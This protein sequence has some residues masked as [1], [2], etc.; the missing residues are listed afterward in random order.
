MIL[1]D[2]GTFFSL[3]YV[4]FFFFTF[5]VIFWFGSRFR[6]ARYNN[7]GGFAE[8]RSLVFAPP[9]AAKFRNAFR[10]FWTG[11]RKDCIGLYMGM[12]EYT[13]I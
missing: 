10:V 12:D 13:F 9:G 4:E 11:F 8:I 2:F 6:G 5:F 7:T 1:S 3:V